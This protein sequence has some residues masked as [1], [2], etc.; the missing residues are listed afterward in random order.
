MSVIQQWHDILSSGCSDGL[1]DLLHPDCVFWSPVVH[2]PQRGR[3]ICFA[4]LAA[5]QQVF[6][7]DF[8]YE[9]EII[10]GHDAVLEFSCRM[11][12]VVINGVD[13]IH[14]EGQYITDFKVMVRPLQAVHKVHEKMM[15]MLA[16]GA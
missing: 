14:W 3:D 8:R 2:T 11:D 6:H 15:A 16:Q 5:A 9:R 10:A 13:I 4:Y 1:R 7:D 12:D